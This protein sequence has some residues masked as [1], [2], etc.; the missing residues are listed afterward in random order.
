MIWGWHLYL[1][2]CIMKPWSG[3]QR[4]LTLSKCFEVR[5]SCTSHMPI[6]VDIT[7]QDLWGSFWVVPLHLQDISAFQSDAAAPL[8]TQSTESTFFTFP[9]YWSCRHHLNA[10]F[11]QRKKC[12][13]LLIQCTELLIQAEAFFGKINVSKD[14]YKCFFFQFL[15]DWLEKLLIGW[16]IT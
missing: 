9:R 8:K 14:M 6:A 7:R 5:E 15:Y 3:S 4:D 16:H 10:L 11:I 2:N 12:P 13:N 1:L